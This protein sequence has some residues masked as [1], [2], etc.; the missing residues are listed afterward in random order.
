MALPMSLKPVSPAAHQVARALQHGLIHH[1]LEVFGCGFVDHG[2]P[3]LVAVLGVAVRAR[4]PPGRAALHAHGAGVFRGDR[5][6]WGLS[7][8]P[9]CD[10]TWGLDC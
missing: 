1:A 8:W 2:A 9:P 7:R 6:G 3:L 5:V 4:D 10:E